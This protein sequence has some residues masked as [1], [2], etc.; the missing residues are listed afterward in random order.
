M[1]TAVAAATATPA[2]TL[3]SL[4]NALIA[5]IL[6]HLVASSGG[7][8]KWAARLGLASRRMSEAVAAAD[9]LWR[10]QCQALGWR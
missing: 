7:S 5:L 8:A 4:P 6:E 2:P 9:S 3:A 1:V 10:S